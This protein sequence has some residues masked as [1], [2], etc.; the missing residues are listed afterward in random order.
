MPNR[1]FVQPARA[2]GLAILFPG[3]TYSCDLPVLH[4]PYR[5]LAQRGFDVLQLQ[6]DYTHESFQT[7]SPSEQAD[8][9]ASDAIAALHASRRQRDYAR[10]VLIG[11]SLGTLVLAHML[12]R[13][14]ERDAATIWLTPL[15]RQPDLLEVALPCKS[16][17]LFVIGTED[18]SYDPKTLERIQAVSCA[19]VLVLE[20]ADHILEV[21]GDIFSSLRRIESLLRAIDDF[22]DSLSID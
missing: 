11:K 6:T 16:P 7:A 19:R 5:L 18:R 8:W 15:L 13:G 20:G 4:Y 1:L 9:L 10:V 14:E 3:L 21:P 12:A 17:A 22:L 2:T